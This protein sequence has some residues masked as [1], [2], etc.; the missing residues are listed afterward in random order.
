[1]VQHALCNSY[2]C[3]V[4]IH[5]R[6]EEIIIWKQPTFLCRKQRYSNSWFSL[7]F[8]RK[9]ATDADCFQRAISLHPD[10]IVPRYFKALQITQSPTLSWNITILSHPDAAKSSFKNWSRTVWFPEMTDWWLKMLKITDRDWHSFL[11]INAINKLYTATGRNDSSYFKISRFHHFSCSEILPVY[12]N[13][14]MS[15]GKT[16]I[17]FCWFLMIAL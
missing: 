9:I 15:A 1:M 7:V 16:L 17:R 3:F 5:T 11:A 12:T 10:G 4:I 2:K 14:T 13:R 8:I 6:R